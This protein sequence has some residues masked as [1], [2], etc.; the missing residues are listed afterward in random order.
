MWKPYIIICSVFVFIIAI[1]II[2][3]WYSNTYDKGLFKQYTPTLGNPSLVYVNNLINSRELP[4]K[5]TKEQ[6][7]IITQVINNANTN[8]NNNIPL[9]EV[10]LGY[11][12]YSAVR[13][14]CPNIDGRYEFATTLALNGCPS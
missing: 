8:F 11:K 6:Q 4:P 12:D 2:V 3:I 9:R 10:S 1:I 13:Y 14:I 7:E 5:P